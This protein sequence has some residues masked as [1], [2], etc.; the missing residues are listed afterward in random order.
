[1]WAARVAGL[2][3]RA[4]CTPPAAGGAVGP[5]TCLGT[6]SSSGSSSALLGKALSLKCT[7]MNARPPLL[8]PPPPPPLLAVVFPPPPTPPA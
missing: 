8:A 7:A 6:N 1:M 3:A 4:G 5:L 2:H